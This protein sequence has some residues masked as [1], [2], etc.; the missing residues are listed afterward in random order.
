VD[1][2][3]ERTITVLGEKLVPSGTDGTLPWERL[4][5]AD[6]AY[7]VS[8]DAQAVHAARELGA[9]LRQRHR[10]AAPEDIDADAAPAVHS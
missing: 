4:R 6:G 10:Y 1:E 8:G 5:H 7:F 3:A 2:G 9:A